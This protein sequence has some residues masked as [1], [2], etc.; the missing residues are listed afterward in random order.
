MEEV[1]KDIPEYEGLYQVSNLGRVKSLKR[2]KFLKPNVDAYGYLCVDL[3]KNKN[4]NFKR[5]HRHVAE[6]FIP[7]LENKPQI[8]H[9]DGNKQNNNVNNLEWV[10]PCENIKHKFDVLGYKQSNCKKVLCVESN[11]VFDSL[12]DASRILGINFKN[13]SAVC[14]G[15]R[16]TAGGYHW[17][18]I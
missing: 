6:A 16:K 5:I 11:R 12:H 2:E 7:N 14:R 15:K 4:H 13:I 1:W 3:Y 10:T 17:N 9:I 18:F 8:N